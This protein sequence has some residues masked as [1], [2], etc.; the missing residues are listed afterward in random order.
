MIKFNS[1]LSKKRSKQYRKRILEI[2]QKVSA[3]HIGGTFSCTEIMEIIF[4][5]F[6]KTKNERECFILS[7]G[8]ASILHYAI[9]EQK[10]IIKKKRY[11]KLLQKKWI[12][13]CT[14]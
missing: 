6:I 2:S 13:R 3:L 7:K 11:G 5:Y 12:L 9:L 1:S 4:N 8:H 14:P 10:K